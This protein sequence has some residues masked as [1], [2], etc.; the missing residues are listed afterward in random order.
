MEAQI[1]V[2]TVW[3]MPAAGAGSLKPAEYPM[4]TPT[5]MSRSV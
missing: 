4:T 1:S 3:D 5:A 2:L